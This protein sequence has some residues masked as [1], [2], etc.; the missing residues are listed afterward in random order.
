MLDKNERNYFPGADV[1]GTLTLLGG[2]LAQ[3][4]IQLAQFGPNTWSGKG[5]VVNY[6]IAPKASVTVTQMQDGFFLD[7]RMSAE[8]ES[9][10]LILFVVAWLFFFPIAIILAVMAYQDWEARMRQ[11][12]Y[13]VWGPLAPRMGPP[14]GYQPMPM[15]APMG[16]PQY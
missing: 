14:P 9:N 11:L 2:A 13:A 16:P 8:F 4:G 10:A 1:N 12:F 3:S 5:S 15:G 7:V 6:G